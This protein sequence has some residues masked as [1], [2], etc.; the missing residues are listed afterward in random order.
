MRRVSEHYLGSRCSRPRSA[1]PK[2]ELSFRHSPHPADPMVPYHAPALQMHFHFHPGAVLGLNPDPLLQS[3]SCLHSM[4][5]SSFEF[6]GKTHQAV[7]RIYSGLWWCSGKG[8]GGWNPESQ[9]GRQ[10]PYPCLFAPVLLSSFLSCFWA[11]L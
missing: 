5:F 6:L 7:P 10:V 9:Y 8:V 3:L 11:T 1:A 2:A 4:W